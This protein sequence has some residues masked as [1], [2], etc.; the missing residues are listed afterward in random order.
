MK[1][2][3]RQVLF[4]HTPVAHP[5]THTH[6]YIP[7][8]WILLTCGTRHIAGNTVEYTT[9]VQRRAPSYN[10]NCSILAPK[11]G[12]DACQYVYLPE[13]VCPG[14]RPVAHI[15]AWYGIASD[16]MKKIVGVYCTRPILAHKSVG[17]LCLPLWCSP[18]NVAS[19]GARLGGPFIEI[20][21][22]EGYPTIA[23]TKKSGRRKVTG[24]GAICAKCHKNFMSKKGRKWHRADLRFPLS[25]LDLSYWLG[26]GSS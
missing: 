20:F 19:S 4:A 23:L 13:G 11:N 18:R 10:D 5:P 8:R 15:Q 3:R 17:C 7:I 26:P 6:I 2:T 1:R 12:G 22:R 9:I 24:H 16:W 25:E 21:A 14:A